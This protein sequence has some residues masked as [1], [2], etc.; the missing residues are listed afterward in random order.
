M[1]LFISTYGDKNTECF[2]TVWFMSVAHKYTDV[3]LVSKTILECCFFAVCFFPSHYPAFFMGKYQLNPPQNYL[4]ISFT[5]RVL[6][7][8]YLGSQNWGECLFIL[9]FRF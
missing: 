2:T 3:R 5:L 8:Q 7:L 4:E 6:V 1:Q 9:N